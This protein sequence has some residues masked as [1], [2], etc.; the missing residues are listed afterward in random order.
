M[1]FPSGVLGPLNLAPFR[2]AASICAC[3]GINTSLESGVRTSES[4]S[5]GAR[6][7][8]HKIV[9]SFFVGALLAGK[10]LIIQVQIVGKISGPCWLRSSIFLVARDIC[11]A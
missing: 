10:M 1:A 7:P 9:G 3:V 6:R 11:R 4:G 8:S 5:Q 2:R